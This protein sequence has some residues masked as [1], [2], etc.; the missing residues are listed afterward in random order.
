MAANGVLPRMFARTHPVHKDPHVSD[1][2][3]D[4][5]RIVVRDPDGLEMGSEPRSNHL[6]RVTSLVI[7]VYI[8]V[9][10]PRSSTSARGVRSAFNPWLHWS[11]RVVRSR[12]RFY[13]SAGPLRYRSRGSS[14]P[15]AAIA[16]LRCDEATARRRSE[17][18]DAIVDPKCGKRAHPP[19]GKTRVQH[20]LNADARPV[21]K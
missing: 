4:R 20:G 13:C 8:T 6:L 1:H 10:S 14:R 12:S 16:I 18:Q 5:A 15:V 11:S 3:A 7:L 21:R 17:R 2:R 19:R 9:A